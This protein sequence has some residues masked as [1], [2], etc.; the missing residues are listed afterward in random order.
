[1]ACDETV[2]VGPL[3]TETS[4]VVPTTHVFAWCGQSGDLTEHLQKTIILKVEKSGVVL[5]KLRLH[6]TFQQL[7]VGI[8]E[9]GQRGL[10]CDGSSLWCGPRGQS[11]SDVGGCSSGGG[12]LQEGSAADGGFHGR[13]RTFRVAL[14]NVCPIKHYAA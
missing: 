6:R 11:L 1:M 12:G 9:G 8:R 10:D 4:E 2:E 14:A 7:Y 3:Q 5:V 13:P